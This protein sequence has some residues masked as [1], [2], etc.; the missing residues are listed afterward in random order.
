MITIKKKRFLPIFINVIA[1]IDFYVKW[2]RVMR[3]A[4]TNAAETEKKWLN[5][6]EKNHW[7][8]SVW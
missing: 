6:E 5:T 3:S 2:Q 7:V 1:Q 8:P 4:I